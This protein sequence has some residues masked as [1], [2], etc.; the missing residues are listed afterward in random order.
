MLLYL[1]F[2]LSFSL[3]LAKH[4]MY[5][6]L[7][8]EEDRLMVEAK[9]KSQ[10]FGT[11]RIG[12]DRVYNLTEVYTYLEEVASSYPDLVT[13]V[14]AGKSFEGRDVKYL[15]ISTTNFEDTSKPIVF[16]E[17]L[18]HAREWVTL[19]PTLYAIDKLVTGNLTESSVLDKVD[20]IIL[21]IANPD[22]YEFSHVQNRFWR[23]NRAT[24]YMANDVCVGVDLNRNFDITWGD[25]SSNNV[26]SETFHGRHP[27]S[28]PEA[29]IVGDILRSNN[30]RIKM[31]MDI[32]STGSMILYGWGDG[33]LVSNALSVHAA[34][35]QMATAI[36]AV[37][38]HWNPYYTVGN[39]AL[40]LYR[41]SGL[42]MDYGSVSNI[43]YSY[44]YELPRHRNALG[45]DRFLVDPALVQ[46]F[47]M[48]TWE[49][50][51]AG[52]KFIRDKYT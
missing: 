4:E 27:F 21:P 8:D 19:P 52:A 13:L 11:A 34:G 39:S 23:K 5:D 51:Q 30:N 41:A 20:W 31:F 10:R 46:Q 47:A 48:E 22:G 29:R 24:G 26:C 35:I 18:L 15:K 40:V 49:G 16:V 45:V 50:I 32:H 7:L 42:A 37:K 12:F 44:V 3:V 6:G 25:F 28:E 14:N 43:P 33:V 2:L 36:D 17:S 9:R 38:T 1:S